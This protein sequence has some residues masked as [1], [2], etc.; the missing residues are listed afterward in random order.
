MTPDEAAALIAAG[1]STVSETIA[2]DSSAAIGLGDMG[3]GNTTAAA[4]IT[5]VFT[6]SPPAVT[7]GRGTGIDDARFQVKVAAIKRAIAINEPNPLDPIDVLSKVGGCEIAFLA[8]VALGAA[9]RR[10]AVVLDGY[11]TTAAALIAAAFAPS[12]R[13]YMLASHLS[14]E[15]GHRLALEHLSLR[16]V[17]DL[18]MRLGEGTGA[19]LAMTILD[20]A[21]SI[22]R[23]MATFDA[24]GVSRS[25]TEV[26]PEA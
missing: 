7:A 2:S 10:C 6:Q 15:P 24:A 23:S 25:T 17:L 3:I 14:A 11:P 18:E 21:L 26:P 22:P 19:A 9:A 5:S 20:A 12:A 13:D 4:A 1:I 8:G 16:P